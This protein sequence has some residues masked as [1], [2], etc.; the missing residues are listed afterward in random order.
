MPDM[1]EFPDV[2]FY[3]L[4]EPAL[5]AP[6]PD[7]MRIWQELAHLRTENQAWRECMQGILDDVDVHRSSTAALQDAIQQRIVSLGSRVAHIYDR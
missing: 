5:S 4:N 2:T 3:V 1:D 6:A 7:E